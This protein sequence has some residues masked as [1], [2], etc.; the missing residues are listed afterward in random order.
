MFKD[1]LSI[2]EYSLI[3]VNIAYSRNILNFGSI[4]Q[5]RKGRIFQYAIYFPISFMPQIFVSFCYSP[6]ILRKFNSQYTMVNIHDKPIDE[7]FSLNVSVMTLI[8]SENNFLECFIHGKHC[9]R[10]EVYTA[11]ILIRFIIYCEK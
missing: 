8:H 6:S 2:A 3:L 1:R 5:E 9:D 11:S 7:I 10:E 4:A